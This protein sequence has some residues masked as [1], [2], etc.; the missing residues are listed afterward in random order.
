M[1]LPSD[2]SLHFKH[3]KGWLLVFF[4][5]KIWDKRILTSVCFGFSPRQVRVWPPCR[6]WRGSK[7]FVA[8]KMILSAPLEQTEQLT[9]SVVSLRTGQP[10][11]PYEVE[12]F[13]SPGR[14]RT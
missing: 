5:Y 2:G 10:G 7:K 1:S 6:P 14:N 12:G 11:S 3:K 8:S 9:V 13:L 4:L